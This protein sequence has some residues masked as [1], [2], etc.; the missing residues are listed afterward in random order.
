M[1]KRIVILGAGESGVGAALLAQAK[2]YDVFVSEASSIKGEFKKQLEENGIPYEEGQHTEALVLNADEVIKSPGIPAA[3][4]IIQ[5]LKVLH[6]PIIGELEF[7]YR[8]TKAKFIGITGTNGK[9]TTTL[10]TYHIL[11]EAGMNVGLAGN[12]GSS[13]AKQVINEEHE[14]YV[15]EV[16][17]FQLDDMYTFQPMVAVVLNITPDHLDRYSGDIVQYANSKMRIVQHMDKGGYFIYFEDNAILSE[18]SQRV[19]GKTN[20]LPISLENINQDGAYIGSDG[21]LVFNMGTKEIKGWQVS[22]SEGP[23]KG[24]HNAI[25]AMA[26]VMAALI[27]GIRPYVIERALKSFQNAPHRMEPVGKINDVSFINDSKATNVDAVYY[28]LGGFTEP[29]I[30]IAGGVDKGNNYEQLSDLVKKHVKAL[31]CLGRDNK[32][33]IEAFGDLVP[34]E[35]EQASM[36]MAVEKAYR[37]A[38]SGDVVL[39]SPACASFDLFSNYEDRGNQFREAVKVL[40]EKIDAGTFQLLKN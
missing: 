15:L 10:L 20:V 21:K 17:S 27:V 36:Q 38:A 40:S 19:I 34:V 13:L 11:K 1:Q 2:G 12:V 25:N 26:A 31:V 39:L 37:L 14:Y 23:L 32:K 24:T 16:S 5:K 9:T 29:L 18:Y 35:E 4:P 8:F 33:L 3:A 6:V 22:L 30:W 7:A 28:A